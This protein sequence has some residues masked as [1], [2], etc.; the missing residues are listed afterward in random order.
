MTYVI[1]RDDALR[2]RRR[3]AREANRRYSRGVHDPACLTCPIGA[4]AGVGRGAACPMAARKRPA[5]SCIH[6]EGEPVESVFCIG[7]VVT[8]ARDRDGAA[9]PH[10]LRRARSLLGLEG[11]VESEYRDSAHALT[12]VT[13]CSAPLERLRTFAEKPQGA[14]AL[15]EA[16]LSAGKSDTPLRATTDGNAKARAPRGG[17][18]TRPSA[19]IELQRGHP[20]GAHRHAAGDAIARARGA[21]A[22]GSDHGRSRSDRDPRSQRAAQRRHRRHGRPQARGYLNEGEPP[23]VG[24]HDRGCSTRMS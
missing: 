3:F 21:G 1:D 18:S 20:R 15:L 6:V 17:C 14:R 13:V 4:A 16:T 19:V 11:L 5:G 10:G 23:R 8:L 22:R 24:G 7:G 9:V 12:D 2:R